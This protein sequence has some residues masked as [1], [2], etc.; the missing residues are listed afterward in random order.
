MTGMVNVTT[1]QKIPLDTLHNLRD[2]GGYPSKFGGLTSR[3][4]L[5]S[6]CL[7]PISKG[8][9]QILLDMGLHLVID[10]RNSRERKRIPCGFENYPGLRY[11]N[12]PLLPETAVA[13]E[14]PPEDFSLGLLY[15][16]ILEKAQAALL[17]VF[18]LIAEAANRKSGLVLFHCTAGKDRTGLIAALL[19]DLARVDKEIIIQDYAM[20]DEN[21]LPVLDLLYQ[22]S[23]V[24]ALPE[25]LVEELMHARPRNME[26]MLDHLKKVYGGSEKYLARIGLSAAE[27]G[28]IIRMI[29]EGEQFL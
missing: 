21:L 22:S 10:L 5:R 3:R 23:E 27:S 25:P 4:F 1:K 16:G 11:H 8:D 20:T 15:I 18:R 19:L 24:S 2:L 17:Q 6:D 13:A 29:T 26:L 7:I 12:I 9:R 14:F 28:A